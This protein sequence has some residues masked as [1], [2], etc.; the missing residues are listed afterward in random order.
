MEVQ[1][2]DLVRLSGEADGVLVELVRLDEGGEF[3]VFAAGDAAEVAQFVGVLP[4]QRHPRAADVVVLLPLLP[5]REGVCERV[6]ELL[7]ELLGDGRRCAGCTPADDA[8]EAVD[9]ERPQD[10]V[11]LRVEE[12]E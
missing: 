10:E 3:E 2:E 8:D 11:E 1:Q 7:E 5:H 4:P 6:G 12:V 9:E